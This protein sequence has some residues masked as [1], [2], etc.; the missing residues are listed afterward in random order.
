MT[1]VHV[2][3]SLISWLYS[4]DRSLIGFLQIEKKRVHI[5]ALSIYKFMQCFKRP[6]H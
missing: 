5:Y 2:E 4:I 6:I 1:V 3:I